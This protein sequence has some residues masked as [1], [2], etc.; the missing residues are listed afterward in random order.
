[1]RS[2]WFF[3]VSVLTLVGV[4]ATSRPVI[5]QQINQ[6]TLSDTLRLSELAV[7]LQAEG[8]D[9]GNVINLD[10]LAGQGGR[11]WQL[12]VAA[13]YHPDRITR[14]V[15]Q[16]LSAGLSDL[17][18]R[19]VQMFFE[20]S[21]GQRILTLEY[22]ART[23]MAQTETADRLI[24]DLSDRAHDGDPRFVAVREF[25]RANDLI[26]LNV[27]GALNANYQFLASFARQ[28]GGTTAE[29]DILAD[30]WADAD[31]VEQNISDWV[32]A[33]LLLA[34]DPLTVEE[35]ARYTEFTKTDAGQ[36]MNRA[37]FAGFETLYNDVNR[38]LGKAAAQALKTQDL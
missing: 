6:R 22:E 8:M 23:V 27:S 32:Y 7:L 31:R 35:I 26:D 11:T 29:K 36:A 38:D 21:L 28:S 34:Y 24:Q 37:L 5:A 16:A 12:Q 3:V 1:M 30:V 20:T 14:A 13:I 9:Y 17:E 18:R 19:Q 15:D 4:L 33:Y 25:V 2:F 10:M